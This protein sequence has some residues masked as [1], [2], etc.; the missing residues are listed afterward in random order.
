MKVTL[1]GAKNS[2]TI[3]YDSH[4][5]RNKFVCLCKYLNCIVPFQQSAVKAKANGCDGMPPTFQIK[6][7][8]TTKSLD[9]ADAPPKRAA[10]SEVEDELQSMAGGDYVAMRR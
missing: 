5:S 3:H 8:Q 10:N 1:C 4:V 7:S 9:S 6:W 2:G